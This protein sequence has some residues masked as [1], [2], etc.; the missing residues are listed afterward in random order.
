M[1]VRRS[2]ASLWVCLTVFLLVACDPG[3][4]AAS[5]QAFAPG[6]PRDQTGLLAGVQF[7]P[8][9]PAPT[10]TGPTSPL[11]TPTDPISPL[12]MPTDP[13]SPLPTP[14]DPTSPL[15]TPT[16]PTSPLPTPTDPT[17]PLPTATAYPPFTPP[18]PTSPPGPSVT[19]TG[20]CSPIPAPLLTPTRTPMPRPTPARTD[21]FVTGGGWIASPPGAYTADPALTGPATFGLVARY[22]RGVNL[23]TGSIQF[24]LAGARLQ[25]HA[26]TYESLQIEGARAMFRGVGTL[27]E[28]GATGGR[29][30]RFL[31]SVVDGQIDGSGLDRIRIK[32]WDPDAGSAIV[33]DSQL[34]APDGASPTTPLSG[35][36]IVIHTG[37]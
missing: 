1:R 20:T 7:S 4:L 16:D 13:T 8:I 9:S 36:S 33:Y 37:R 25:L 17:S 14:T 5:L 23:P 27:R 15:P 28:A 12:P 34:G 26:A 31:V 24:H 10:P 11:P 22:R 32:I 3:P 30:G 19:P 18:P 35:G 29:Q 2:F 6:L 21:S